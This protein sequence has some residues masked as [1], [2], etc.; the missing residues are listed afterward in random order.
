[1]APPARGR[2][3]QIGSII[4]AVAQGRQPSV[5]KAK[6]D[7][8]THMHAPS[9]GL[10]KRRCS[11]S[12]PP[13][14]SGSSRPRISRTS[15]HWSYHATVSLFR[16]ALKVIDALWRLTPHSTHS[17]KILM[18]QLMAQRATQ[19]RDVRSLAMLFDGSFKSLLPAERKRLYRIT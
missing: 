13:P 7:R 16:R 17:T 3:L 11:R 6:S 9:C 4:R 15:A 2:I 18:M 1:M 5:G 8:K 14:T 10:G 12:H 19:L